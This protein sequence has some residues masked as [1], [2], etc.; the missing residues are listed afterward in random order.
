MFGQHTINTMQKTFKQYQKEA[1]IKWTILAILFLFTGLFLL[2][3]ITFNLLNIPLTISVIF[4][5][6]ALL[7]GLIIQIINTFYIRERISITALFPEM[8]AQHKQ[9]NEIAYEYIPYA[10][11]YK[12]LF[13]ESGLFTRNA[14]ARVRYAIKGTTNDGDAFILLNLSLIVSSGSA[15]T[16]IF[17]GI[18][19]QITKKNEANMQIKTRY[20]PTLKGVKFEKTNEE[21]PFKIYQEVGNTNETNSKQ[22]FHKIKQL[23]HQLNAKHTYFS[24]TE[25]AHY[26]AFTAPSIPYKMR[27]V[28]ETEVNKV[29]DTFKTYLELPNEL[30]NTI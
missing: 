25:D 13:K 23:H 9:F 6:I 17:R 2:V 19:Y 16:E 21:A 3:E 29:L 28:N 11:E 8:I 12:N 4:G 14:F 20:R 15:S 27:T 26:F 18:L 7:T 5:S 30:T 10:K 1:R 22:Y 24:T